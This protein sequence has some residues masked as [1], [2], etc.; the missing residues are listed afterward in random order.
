MK[1]N[2]EGPSNAAYWHKRAT[3]AEAEVAQARQTA[4]YWKAQHLAGNARIGELHDELA[5]TALRSADHLR[6][7]IKAEAKCE[8]LEMNLEAARRE[9]AKVNNEFGSENADWP[10]AWRRVAEL[11]ERAGRLW[12]ENE[13]LR[14][15]AEFGARWRQDS[16]LATWFPITAEKLKPLTDEQINKLVV[17]YYKHADQHDLSPHSIVRAI[18]AAH[19]IGA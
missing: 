11:K 13:T 15:D 10:E 12:R 18:E 7:A 4:E 8:V 6:R 14:A 16:S 5:A 9:L 1:L 17:D 2:D 19:G 3:E